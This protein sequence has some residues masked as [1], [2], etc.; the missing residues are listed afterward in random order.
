MYILLE[1]T[2]TDKESIALY[3]NFATKNDILAEYETKLGQAMKA[4]AYKGELLIAF[5][6]TGKILA[7][8]STFKDEVTFSPRLVWVQ[9]TAQGESDPDQSKKADRN[10]LEADYHIKKGSAMKNSDVKGLL[11]LGIDNTSIV[12]NDYYVRP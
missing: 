5:E 1:A 4:E 6:H 7:Q 2:Y 8:G 9:S 10:I 3:T 12:I 11:L